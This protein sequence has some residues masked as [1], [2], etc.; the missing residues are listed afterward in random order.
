MNSTVSGTNLCLSS[1]ILDYLSNCLS[2]FYLLHLIVIL[3]FGAISTLGDCR[4]DKSFLSVDGQYGCR[5]IVLKLFTFVNR[6]LSMLLFLLLSTRR[7]KKNR[8]SKK[9]GRKHLLFKFK[10]RDTDFQT[11]KR[12]L[13][14]GKCA[15]TTAD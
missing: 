12:L 8:C 3:F 10:A 15:V 2:D 5:T 14:G 7:N 9:T 1:F 4:K 13:D 6:A 11:K